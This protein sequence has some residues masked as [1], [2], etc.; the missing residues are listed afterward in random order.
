MAV[1]GV[2]SVSYSVRE[3]GGRVASFLL[4]VRKLRRGM[5]NPEF[6]PQRASSSPFFLEQES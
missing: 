5:Q 4:A 6:I 2:G 3:G 1:V